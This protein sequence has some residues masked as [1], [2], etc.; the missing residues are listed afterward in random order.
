MNTEKKDLKNIIEFLIESNAIE[1]EYGIIAFQDAWKAWR[2]L[3]KMELDKFSF[4]KLMAL[5][6]ILMKNLNP[7]I[8]GIIRDGEVTVGGDF[9]TPAYQVIERLK[10]LML[11]EPKTEGEIK[12]WHI[13]FEAV[14]PF[15]D[16]NG[17]TGRLI[18]NWQR[19]RNG[20]PTLVIHE[21]EE[22]MEYY[23]WFD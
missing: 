17:R 19:V 15:W 2:F 22:Q 7:G 21:G 11:F 6:K 9:V 16:G 3:D 14:H 18:M 12:E 23:K 5:H 10:G 1:K 8:A 4:D 13:R 20:F